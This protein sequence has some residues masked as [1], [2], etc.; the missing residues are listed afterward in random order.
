MKGNLQLQISLILLTCTLSP[1]S[2]GQKY[3]LKE[4][5][6]PS[7]ASFSVAEDINNKGQVCG[8]ASQKG[9]LWDP[10][11]GYSTFQL[12]NGSNDIFGGI[13]DDGVIAGDA[14]NGS[15]HTAYTWDKT[16]GIQQLLQSDVRGSAA[17]DINNKGQV[18]GQV[19]GYDASTNAAR[20]DPGTGWKILGDLSI[21]FAFG[22]NNRGDAVGEWYNGGGFGIQ[23]PFL[24]TD[25]GGMVDLGLP[26]D[27][28][29]GFGSKINDSGTI[30]GVWAR[31][32]DLSFLAWIRKPDG[33]YIRIEPPLLPGQTLPYDINNHNQ[34]VGYYTNV[35]GTFSFIWSEE[36]G[37]QDLGSLTIGGFAGYQRVIATGI[38]DTGYISATGIVNGVPHALLLTPVPEP[39][40]WLGFVG[41]LGL[42]G[43]RKQMKC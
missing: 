4:L 2:W 37:L 31:K 39:P 29:Q 38:S 3:E 15:K 10:S 16:N 12:G 9:F 7:G 30:V 19:I 13:N 33:E 40:L 18:A 23:T 1:I 34:V 24:Y 42:F 32:E 27:M 6:N 8:E 25:A 21:S 26:S 43:F 28:N 35:N 41:V 5:G 14:H 11:S 17:R 20:Y 36:T 22:I